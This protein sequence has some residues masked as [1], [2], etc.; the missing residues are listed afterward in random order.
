MLKL[1]AIHECLML[2]N[3]QKLLNVDQRFMRRFFREALVEGGDFSSVFTPITAH[4]N[5]Q[6]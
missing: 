5:N 6:H 2:R 3:N 4:I 1:K